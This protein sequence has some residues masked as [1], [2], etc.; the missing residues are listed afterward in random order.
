[1][2]RIL[3]KDLEVLLAPQAA[4]CV[5]IY[6]PFH[7]VGRDA[8]QDMIRLRLLLDEAEEQLVDRGMSLA[9]ARKLLAPARALPDDEP[10]WQNRGRWMAIFVTPGLMRTFDGSGPMEEGLFVDDVFHV[11][12]LL[13]LVTERDRFFLLALSQN[14]VRMF[15]GDSA[16]LEEIELPDLPKSLDQ[17]LNIEGAERGSQVHAAVRGG[18]TARHGKQES[19]FHGHGGEADTS[20]EELELF[21][22]QVA[23][24]VDR[25]LTDERA[26][27][28]LATVAETVPVW[29]SASGYKHTLDDFVAGCPDYLT[30]AEL[31]AKAW[32]LVQPEL[33]RDRDL[34]HRRLAHAQ[35]NVM[36]G[37]RQVIPAA[38]MGRVDTLFIDCT[39]PHWGRYDAE[40]LS[41]ELHD[42]PRPGDADLMELA[43]VE[44]LRHRGHVFALTSE[45]ATGASAEALLRY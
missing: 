25:R 18:Q 1:M 6:V 26:P 35:G 2:K 39:R 24:V 27:L 15:E 21:V 22:R 13:P 34:L 10:A 36:S 16:G 43:A 8:Q 7:L 17:A 9:L 30:P 42:Q 29:R 4:A 40:R 5:S 31:H 20:K 19:V 3:R 45:T 28:V 11:R 41:V 38:A 33:D 14:A 32:P 23:S 37:L 12:P 44:T